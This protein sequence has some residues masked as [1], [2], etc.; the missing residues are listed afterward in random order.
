MLT[1]KF[2]DVHV[3]LKMFVLTFSIII[4]SFITK[5]N[6]TD[7]L[8][9]IFILCCVMRYILIIREDWIIPLDRV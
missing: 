2:K 6:I 7:L 8:Y 5:K 1:Q 3:V 4:G 9:I